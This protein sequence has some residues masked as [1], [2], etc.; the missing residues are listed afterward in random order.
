M[1]RFL[2]A[3]AFGAAALLMP[4]ASAEATLLVAVDVNGAAFCVA[5]NNVGCGFGTVISDTDAAVGIIRIADQTIGGDVFVQGSVQIA[6]VAPPDNI[7][8]TS[9]LQLANVSGG[10]LDVTVV[11]SATDFVGPAALASLSGSATF[12]NAG[13]AA[14]FT[15]AWYNDP[16]NDQGAEDAGDTPGDLLATFTDTSIGGATNAVAN[17]ADVAVTDPANFSMT[18]FTQILDLA[19]NAVVVGNSMTETKPLV[20]PEPASMVLFGLGL[21][22]AGVMSRRRRIARN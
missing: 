11:V 1:K 6:T 20:V 4:T 5:D 16:A 22:G 14:S 17:N 13:N 19:N 7:L 15:Q 2:S 8:N 18:L 12:Q 21:L 10:L 3:A 9:S